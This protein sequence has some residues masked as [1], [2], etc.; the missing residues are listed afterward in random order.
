[1]PCIPPLPQPLS[2]PENNL[3]LPPCLTLTLPAH[4]SPRTP[5]I[6]PAF[7]VP[8]AS[9]IIHDRGSSSQF[10][11]TVSNNPTFC[12]LTRCTISIAQRNVFKDPSGVQIREAMMCRNRREWLR[13]VALA[14]RT[15]LT[16]TDMCGRG[17]QDTVMVGEGQ[18][19]DVVSNLSLSPQQRYPL[20]S[21]LHPMGVLCERANRK[22]PFNIFMY[23]F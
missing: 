5:N 22:I 16:L 20:Y 8:V 21:T 12:L 11:N 7:T 17:A 14:S 18:D 6:S 4:L 2:V 19:R 1:L 3:A 10:Q 23:Y 13:T 9:V 15:N